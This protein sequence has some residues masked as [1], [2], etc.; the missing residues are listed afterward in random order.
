[1]QDPTAILV[2]F[3]KKAVS[4]SNRYRKDEKQRYQQ[5]LNLYWEYANR[6]KNNE[7]IYELTSLMFTYLNPEKLLPQLIFKQ[8]L[9]DEYL[10][11]LFLSSV[12]YLN[13]DVR[14]EFLRRLRDRRPFAFGLLTHIYAVLAEED[15]FFSEQATPQMGRA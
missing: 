13:P 11:T 3:E 6:K 5:L 2:S 8:E 7:I 10:V 14:K 15:P 9:G 4:I 1:M 12:I